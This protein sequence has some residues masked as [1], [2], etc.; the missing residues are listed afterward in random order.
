MAHSMSILKYGARME[1][2]LMWLRKMTEYN[3]NDE[4]ASA[5]VVNPPI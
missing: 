1:L 3:S 5:L 4:F 2:Q